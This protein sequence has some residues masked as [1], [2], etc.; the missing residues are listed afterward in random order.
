MS[1]RMKWNYKIKCKSCEKIN[2]IP[3]IKL[4][5]DPVKCK[6]GFEFKTPIKLSD[7]ENRKSQN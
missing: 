2:I 1:K 4:G 3:K 5:N 7:Y 6:C